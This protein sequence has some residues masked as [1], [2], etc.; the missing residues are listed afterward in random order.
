M[1][2]EQDID[3]ELAALRKIAW[4][5]DALFYIPRTNISVGLDNILGL[6]PVVG[7]TM[8]LLPSVWLIWKARQLGATPGALAYMTLNT[9]ADYFIGMV[10][11][12]GDLFDVLYNANIRNYRALERNL[13]KRAARAAVVQPARSL[14]LPG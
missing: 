8:A 1:N 11:I 2:I 3:F 10:P 14:P 4:R 7:D 5:M 6:V 9:L 12:V 13:N